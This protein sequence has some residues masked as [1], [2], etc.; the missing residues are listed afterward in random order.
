MLLS[1]YP[2]LEPTTYIPSKLAYLYKHCNTGSLEERDL[3]LSSSV[4]DRSLLLLLKLHSE[5]K[6]YF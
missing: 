6:Q 3:S 1:M 5:N 4:V 2:C